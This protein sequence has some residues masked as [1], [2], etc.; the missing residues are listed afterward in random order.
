MPVTEAMVMVHHSGI[1]GG[2]DITPG[3]LLEQVVPAAPVI[4]GGGFMGGNSVRTK[5][6]HLLRCMKI[7]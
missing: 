7:L 4:E 3:L 1:G 2:H 5:T 6:T